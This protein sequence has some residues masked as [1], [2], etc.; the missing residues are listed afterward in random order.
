MT[1][2]AHRLAR[3]PASPLKCRAAEFPVLIEQ[4]GPHVRALSLDCF[5]T[6]LWRRTAS[7]ADVFFEMA[8]SEA[9]RTLG[10]DATLRVRAERMA[11]GLASITKQSTEVKLDDIYRA[12]F[13]EL[14]EIQL[15]SLREAELAAEIAACY[16][17]PATV[18]LMRAAKA[19]GLRIVIV[20]DTYLSEPELRRL[21]TAVLPADVMATIQRI[22]CSCEH[23]RAKA[24]GLFEEV[25]QSLGLKSSDLLHVGDNAISDVVAPDK[26]GVFAAHF[27]QHGRE[28]EEIL[29]LTNV[30]TSALRA[31]VR[32]QVPL[33]SP[34]RGVLALDALKETPERLLGYHALGP[35][36]Y[37]FGRFVIDE[38]AAL[39]RQGKRPK[40][41]FL[42]RD[43]YLP[44]RVCDQIAG[45]AVGRGVAISRFVAYAASFRCQ[46]DVDGYLAR[47]AGS[48][49]FDSMA[50]QL[51]LPPEL[52]ASIIEK[53]K[54]APKPIPSFIEQVRE[55]SVLAVIVEASRSYRTR[56]FRYL[57]ATIGLAAGDTIV[58]VDLGYEGTAQRQLEPVFRDELKVDVQGR[59]LIATRVPGWQTSR[60]G[61]LDPSWCDDRTL[62]T[63][64]RYIAL[65]EDL[66]TAD[67]QSVVDYSEEGKPIG[68]EQL[69]AKHQADRVRATQ[70]EVLAFARDMVAFSRELG[71]HPSAEELRSAALGS[72]A[73]LLF[74]PLEREIAYL[75]GFRLEMNLATDDSFALFDRQKG[76]DGLRRR[77][78]FFMEQ[79]LKTQ[80]MNYPIELRAAG[81][82]LAL[83][84][85]AQERYGL[86]LAHSDLSMRREP[87]TV[88]I[89]RGSE[90]TT[91]RLDARATHDGY[92]SLE[93]PVGDCSISFAVLFG[94]RYSSLQIASL[95]LIRNK[96]LYKDT[97]SD[98]TEDISEHATPE[99]MRQLDHNVYECVSASAF[100]Y[101]APRSALP[102]PGPAT[103]RI[104]FRPL[105]MRAKQG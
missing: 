60:K 62:A 20:S 103:V 58:L 10:L 13:P 92:F 80:R 2:A 42:M 33:L 65:L 75:E 84:L 51:L 26:L 7:P 49:R 67:G 82:E 93:V 27:V 24:D 55:A 59:Y 100:V 91:A 38:V 95:D 101:V 14:N 63:L 18:Q 25:L 73:R 3:P 23:G 105:V 70:A 6:L 83:T 37:A 90:T 97:E 102:D 71:L 43:A 15:R 11:R 87:L 35:L 40:V 9:F 22:F 68:A 36:L 56:L 44:Q 50:R 5:D 32:H 21:L 48:G 46:A 41:L 31:E 104:V 89:N 16:A 74:F 98:L 28:A 85:L 78:L 66:C 72:L 61:L 1:S 8:Q 29:R 12:A 69:I 88:L 94:Q 86:E 96:A 47:S 39:E 19:R 64:T 53:A 54:A 76:L 77:G 81:M 79:N 34:F 57:E 45:R 52:A 17:F 99:E 30:A 4:F